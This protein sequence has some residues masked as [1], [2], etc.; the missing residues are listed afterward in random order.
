MTEFGVTPL[1]WSA[2][3]KGPTNA[4][5]PTRYP[6]GSSA[7]CGVAVA[8][9]IVPMCIG[10]DGGGSI[11][12]P[13]ALNGVFGLASTF[14]RISWSSLTHEITMIKSGPLAATTKDAALSF[15]VMA[16]P[17]KAGELQDS[18]NSVPRDYYSEMYGGRGCLQ[19]D[20]GCG[21]PPVKVTPN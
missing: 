5:D 13:A 10:F 20:G 12:I 9:G 17:V 2:H 19:T 8:L 3:H 7:G 15:V 4:H 6:G 21:L 14:G 16:E 1:G 11:R 18:I